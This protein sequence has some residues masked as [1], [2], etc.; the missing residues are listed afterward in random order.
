MCN[1]I[2]FVKLFE[3]FLWAP[4]FMMFFNMRF[5]DFFQEGIQFCMGYLLSTDCAFVKGR[6]FS[7]ELLRETSSAKVMQAGDG[8]SRL[9]QQTQANGTFKVSR[10]RRSV[11]FEER[12]KIAC[13]FR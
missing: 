9:K 6:L 5:K 3:F 13:S 12:S 1:H 7:R 2:P 10:H 8:S 4:I 11:W